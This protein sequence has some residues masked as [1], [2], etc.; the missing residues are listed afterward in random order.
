MNDLSPRDFL[1]RRQLVGALRSL[2]R[3]DFSVRLPDDLP[4]TDG[5]IAQLF[6]EV[7]VLEQQMTDEFERLSIVVGKEGK[8]SQRG[9]VRGATGGWGYHKKGPGDAC[10]INGFMAYATAGMRI[11]HGSAV[12]NGMVSGFHE[13]AEARCI[14]NKAHLEGDGP[15]VG[16]LMAVHPCFPQNSPARIVAISLAW[17]SSITCSETAPATTK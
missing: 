4:G 16:G 11:A 17:P 15:N 10:V 1:D 8:I 14:I 6:N 12:I 7:V 13:F 9:R 2:R 3:G 5:E